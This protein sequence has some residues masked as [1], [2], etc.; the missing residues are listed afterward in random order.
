MT[1]PSLAGV[2]PAVSPV[3]PAA[4]TPPERGFSEVYDADVTV[5]DTYLSEGC[6]FEVTARLAGHYRETVFYNRD[7][8]IDRVTAHPSFRS[9]LSSPTATVRTA[10]VGLDRYV[11]NGDGTI[12]IFGTGI[13]LKLKGGER[14]VGLW[15]LVLDPTTG[16]L[17]S[18]EYHGRFDVDA[19]GTAQALCDALGSGTVPLLPDVHAGSTL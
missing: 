15:R 1:R 18:E 11:E 16:E 6:G 14:A 12:S 9:I 17:V 10:D 8:S 19:E 7:G 2:L 5:V 4:A 3:G 13:H